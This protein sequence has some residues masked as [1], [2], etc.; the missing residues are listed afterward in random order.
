MSL[1]LSGLLLLLVL[2]FNVSAQVENNTTLM[3]IAGRPVTVGEFMSIYQKNNVKGETIDKKS[4]DEYLELFIN[5]KLKVRQ[6]EDLGLD[7]LS[8]FMKELDG[9]RDQLAKPYFTYETTMNHLLQ[10]AYERKQLDLRASHIYFRVKP[11][12][13]PQDTLDAFNKAL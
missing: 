7:T 12:A 9:Y 4:M 11:D 2:V 3:T 13:T 1:K 10:E 6:A 5:F 8:S